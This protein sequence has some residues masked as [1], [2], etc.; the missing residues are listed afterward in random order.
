MKN[1]LSMINIHQVKTRLVNSYVVEYPDRLLIIDVASNCHR[2]VLGFI[3]QTLQ[4]D[5]DD[6]ALVICTH[7]DPDHIGGVSALAS[8]CDAQIA[9]PLSSKALHHKVVG[10]PKGFIVKLATTL[11][12]GL[13]PRARDMYF[14]KAR[15]VA[16]RKKAKFTGK[17]PRLK[18]KNI[19]FHAYRLK[20]GTTVPLFDDWQVVH[21]P[22]HSWDSC[23]FYHPSSGSLITGDT[24]LCSAK[25][26]RILVPAILS[27]Q[28]QMNE[29]LDKL[30]S[31]NIQSVYPGHGSV[32]SGDI[33]F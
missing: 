3:E 17:R 24:L 8:L 16:A 28:T 26:N 22:G 18:R 32:I 6:V 31:L 30:R 10:D 2:Y 23:C 25:Q 7:D 20:G 15:N 21:T 27:N 4:R 29:S 19:R 14:N 11:R 5:I 33:Q 9:I 12:E 13:T 1:T